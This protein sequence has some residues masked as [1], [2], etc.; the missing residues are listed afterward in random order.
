MRVESI[1]AGWMVEWRRGA[2]R[3]CLEWARL[4]STEAMEKK[5]KREMGQGKG[6]L[7]TLPR[8][9]IDM[10]AAPLLLP[11][12]LFRQVGEKG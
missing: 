1:V 12:T 2:A 4:E 5:R 9:S 10:S 8:L 6:Q 3:W 7:Y 11:L